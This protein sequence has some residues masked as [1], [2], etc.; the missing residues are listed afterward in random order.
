MYKYIR[1]RTKYCSVSQFLFQFCE[2]KELDSVENHFFDFKKGTNAEDDS[3]SSP[4]SEIPTFLYD[5]ELSEFNSVLQ[6]TLY[7]SDNNSQ[8][9]LFY[10]STPIEIAKDNRCRPIMTSDLEILEYDENFPQPESA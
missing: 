4:T 10:L 5:S 9:R 6:N 2:K 7:L 3:F 1:N 8:P